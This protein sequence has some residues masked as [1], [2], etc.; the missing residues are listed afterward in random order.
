MLRRS[1]DSRILR[2]FD[3]SVHTIGCSLANQDPVFGRPFLN[4]GTVPGKE[5]VFAR[6]NRIVRSQ[7]ERSVLS[8]SPVEIESRDGAGHEAIT[9]IV[10]GV[11]RTAQ[12]QPERIRE[13]GADLLAE[14]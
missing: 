9:R 1:E 11:S 8:A 13:E 7:F 2:G 3:K 10:H 4:R 12:F 6:L 14:K 5:D